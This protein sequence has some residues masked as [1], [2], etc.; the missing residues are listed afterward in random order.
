MKKRK[1]AA[2]AAGTLAAALAIGAGT[3]AGLRYWMGDDFTPSGIERALRNNQVLFQEKPDPQA[4]QD[5][6]GG[7]DNAR[8]EKDPQADN[9]ES[10]Q[11]DQNGNFLFQTGGSQLSG[12]TGGIL[13]ENGQP[14]GD[15]QLPDQIFTPGGG[16][17]NTGN[18]DGTGGTGGTGG[19]SGSTTLPTG[20][21]KDPPA[22]KQNPSTFDPDWNK[23]FDESGFTPAPDPWMGTI[24]PW[25]M[26]DENAENQLYLGQVIPDGET[27][28]AS[29]ITYIQGLDSQGF[30]E[31]YYWGAQDYGED[32]YIVVRGVR[33]NG[34]EWQDFPVTVPTD[35]D[36]EMEILVGW[37][38]RKADEMEEFT[39]SYTLNQAR[40]MVLRQVPG[41]GETLSKENVL[42]WSNQY[43]AIGEQFQLLQ[44]QLSMLADKPEALFGP[45]G[46]VLTKLFR[47]WA[48]NGELVPWIYT[49]SAGRHLLLP[50]GYEP[51]GQGYSAAV[52]IYFANEDF[53]E[54]IDSGESN[55]Y[56]SVTAAPVDGEGTMRIPM[57]AQAVSLDKSQSVKKLVLPSTLQL[58]PDVSQ[59]G[60]EVTGAY[61]VEPGNPVFSSKD[62]LLLSSDGSVIRGV[63][64]DVTELYADENIAAIRPLKNNRVEKL[65]IG[66]TEQLPEI[67]YEKLDDLKEIYVPQELLG[68]LYG[69]DAEEIQQRGIR[70]Y[71]ESGETELRPPFVMDKK[72]CILA[73]AEDTEQTVQLP[74]MDRLT[75]C[76]GAFTGSEKLTTLVLPGKLEELTLEPGCFRDSSVDVILCPPEQLEAVKAE[77]KRIGETRVTAACGQ[78]TDGF[79]Y[80]EIGGGNYRLLSA[81][82]DVESFD[83]IEGVSITEIGSKAFADC[84]QLRW[85]RLPEAVTK[86][87]EEAFSGCTALE[88]MVIQNREKITFQE[89]A[90]DGCSTLR[91][92]G[93]N[94]REIELPASL[95]A[96]SFTGYY[97]QD[98]LLG[99]DRGYPYVPGDQGIIWAVTGEHCTYDFLSCDGIQTLY[100]FLNGTPIRLLGVQSVIPA[101]TVI[102]LP[103]TTIE[104][105]LN[106]FRNVAGPY[107]LDWAGLPNLTIIGAS[108]FR[109]CDLTGDVV[110]ANPNTV[111]LESSSFSNS[112]ITSFRAARLNLSNGVFQNCQKLESITM[113]LAPWVQQVGEQTVTDPALLTPALVAG[114]PET[115]KIY[116]E[117]E[118]P[119]KLGRDSE[120]I[121]FYLW[122]EVDPEN[123]LVVPE[124]SA[125]KYFDAWFYPYIGYDTEK[126]ML[127]K[128][129]PRFTGDDQMLELAVKQAKDTAR[130][131]L[132]RMISGLTTEE[133][134]TIGF[135]TM[136]SGGG[137]M[138]IGAPAD[139]RVANLLSENIGVSLPQYVYSINGWAFYGCNQLE[140]VIF[141]YRKTVNYE[142][143]ISEINS[144][145]FF[146]DFGNT[147]TILLTFQDTTPPHLVPDMF[148]GSGFT[149]RSDGGS[150]L[151]QVPEGYEEVYLNAWLADLDGYVT[152][153]ELLQMM[154]WDENNQL[155]IAQNGFTVTMKNG[156]WVL[157]QVPSDADGP[158]LTL[159]GDTL[160]L[161]AGVKL[162][163]IAAGAFA[164]ASAYTTVELPESL[165]AIES[166]AFQTGGETLT[167]KFNGTTPPDLYVDPTTGVFDFGVEDLTIQVPEGC[168]EG[169]LEKWKYQLSDLPTAEELES[170]MMAEN[171]WNARLA[172]QEASSL[173]IRNENR[174]RKA[175]GLALLPDP[176]TH[177]TYTATRDGIRLN[178]VPTYVENITLDG[179]TMG[180]EPGTKL[181]EINA[182]SFKD[183]DLLKRVEIPDTV[184]AI[185]AKAFTCASES[186]TLDMTA[187]TK[188]KTPPILILLNKEPFTFGL[189][190]ENA[191]VTVLVRD[192]ETR[193]NFIDAWAPYFA[194]ADSLEQLAEQ[195]AAAAV[196]EDMTQ[197]EQEAARADAQ[198]RAK[199][200][201]RA[202]EQTLNDLV[203][204]PQP[205][206]ETPSAAV[207]TE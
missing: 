173:L 144:D 110:L 98:E 128:M 5:Q 108:A 25:I 62:G 67:L 102:Q 142:Q 71:T 121:R 99:Q 192:E 58:I 96:V 53:E 126:D 157:T 37:R 82:K 199:E 12:S 3:W 140:Q 191:R 7:E 95:G 43:P 73:L 101:G 65:R 31:D 24:F 26:K 49:V 38:Y 42:N 166:G 115:I 165:T 9:N 16:N 145:A 171:G 75:L 198:A 124:G 123:I 6:N 104:I 70:V 172:E 56:Q 205:P 133:D 34:G 87:D 146:I 153:E 35:P 122:D 40:V 206:E 2:I 27:V 151:V 189:K 182:D 196:T 93:S 164:G 32:K 143:R 90:L 156:E 52:Q 54:D 64:T 190:K 203:V 125:Q 76:T 41:D 74:D 79:T 61:E 141:P 47:G 152:R 181:L 23:E 132:T 36:T 170:R 39:T 88:G 148:T 107:E 160:G 81:Q 193:R 202:A 155:S 83:G 180:L 19:D 159:D 4:T 92:V 154:G 130:R 114:C 188:D 29:L 138:L 163:R 94:A 162:S 30:T 17:G 161:P 178:G 15:G 175:M 137:L 33:F 177:F 48:E 158:E 77:L 51:L 129:S 174:L 68:A 59:N 80:V 91:F 139:C 201:I 14:A 72:N 197:Q 179:T 168:Q 105:A 194:G 147:G 50:A 55:Y 127:E 204:V 111:K 106:T 69:R 97:P 136:W 21:W 112:D 176:L 45:S 184:D 113:S 183:C 118:T 46:T 20:D 8:W 200:M 89:N 1:A 18:I 116:L 167:L 66:S 169:Y 149:F 28:Y 195:L 120:G 10:P 135:N 131:R 109:D 13:D 134:T 60:L 117:N 86:V 78:M 11:L 185:T 103:E 63:P 187:W 119:P 44:M 57:Y 150:V 186:L 85:V 84:T 100:A 22:D 207:E